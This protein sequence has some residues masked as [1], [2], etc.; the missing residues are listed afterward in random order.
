MY[1]RPLALFAALLLLPAPLIAD[2][3]DEGEPLFNGKDLTGWTVRGGRHTFEARDGAIVGTCVAGQPNGFLCT[4]QV[5]TNFVLTM[6]ILPDPRLNSGVQIRSEAFD[7]EKTLEW[8]NQLGEVKTHTVPA[9][10]VH[11]YQ[12]EIDPTPRAFSGGIY[13]EA[14]RGWLDK[15]DDDEMARKAFKTDDWNLYRIEARGPSIKTWVNGV[16]VADIEDDMTPAGFIGLQVH[17]SKNPGA[18]VQW[19]NLRIEVLP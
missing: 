17:S 7:T 5:Y 14:R 1:Q 16:P 19:R 12:V 11:G 18:Q 15:P 9:G 4:D 6:E 13:D 3:V 8:T 2:V 10:R